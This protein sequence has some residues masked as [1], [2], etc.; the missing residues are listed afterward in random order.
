MG[1]RSGESTYGVAFSQPHALAIADL[2]GDGLNDIIVGKRR[3]AHGPKGDVEPDGEPVLY[4]FRLV[5]KPVVKFIPCKIDGDSGVG[6]QLTVTDVTGDGVPDVLT[7]SK[8][9][10]F[11]FRAERRK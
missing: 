4:W 11:V 5:R 7:V 3:W 10:A 6:V 2:D 8:L 9:G 1:D